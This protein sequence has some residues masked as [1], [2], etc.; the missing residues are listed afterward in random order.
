MVSEALCNQ[1]FGT[2]LALPEVMRAMT[3]RT[4]I[5]GLLVLLATGCG[6]KVT[7][8][9][10]SGGNSNG[11]PAGPGP[12]SL[13][14]TQQQELARLSSALDA[15]QA[16]DSS[17]LLAKHPMNELPAL[18][19]DPRS[20]NLLDRIQASALALDEDELAHLGSNG[21]VISKRSAFPELRARLH[22]HLFGRSA[23]CTSARTPSWRRCTRL[24]IPCWRSP[25]ARR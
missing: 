10:G 12:G 4:T 9:L 24:M 21:F 14:P 23:G 13:N 22:G 20:S 25:R 16:L 2:V 7:P 8:P 18:S 3:W 17:A 5:G 15:S 1:P 11:N 19:Y 6:S